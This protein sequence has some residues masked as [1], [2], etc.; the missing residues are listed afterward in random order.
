MFKTSPSIQ[1]IIA[2]HKP[3]VVPN[4]KIYLP[5]HV[6]SELSKNTIDN[7][8]GDNTGDNISKKN[9]TFC[10]LTALYWA[11]KNLDTEYIGLVHYRRYFKN[12][13]SHEKNSIIINSE[14]NILKATSK[15]ISKM[16]QT[17]SEPIIKE[18]LQS[19]N[20]ILPKKRHYYIENLHNHYCKT[21]N[22]EP[23]LEVRKIIEKRS[24]QYLDEFDKLKTRRSAHI[25]NMLIMRH[26][27]LNDYCSWLFPILFELEEKINTASWSDFQKR[28]I[29]RISERL[30]DVW[31]N[32]NHISYTEL[33]V[34]S[35]ET[36]NWI[37]KGTG[38]L[39]AKFLRRKYEKSW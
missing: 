22:P 25:Y 26:D 31:I 6:G 5:I 14:T 39:K 37:K 12:P 19:A 34:I 7:F 28:Y 3:Y 16:R 18:I 38:F 8:V 1:I 27:I 10:E 23:L 4:D 21:M 30:L 29:G 33:P 9:P 35:T 15:T 17:L 13:K 32:V 2:S 20:V 11:W 36:A 24:P